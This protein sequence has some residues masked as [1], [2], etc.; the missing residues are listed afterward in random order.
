MLSALDPTLKFISRNTRLAGIIRSIKREDIPEYPQVPLREVLVNAI[1]NGNYALPG[2]IFVAIFDD[3]LEIQSPGMLP[4][5]VTL[6]DLKSGVSHIRNRVIAR[7]FRELGLVEE[8]G[9]GYRRIA[10]YCKENGYPIPE[11]QEFGSA[12]RVIFYPHE[13]FEKVQELSLEPAQVRLS[14]RQ[15]EVI[16]IF[17]A[18]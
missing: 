17:E 14:G 11:W 16:N 7:V 10:N 2:R 18:K 8:W 15:K 3:R 1:V 9:S 6:D 12:V 13:S 4:Y 5:G